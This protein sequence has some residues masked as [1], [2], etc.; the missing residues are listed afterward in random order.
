MDAT[1]YNESM[2]TDAAEAILIGHY[3]VNDK[4]KWKNSHGDGDSNSDRDRNKNLMIAS[5]IQN[6]ES[7]ILNSSLNL[8]SHHITDTPPTM[9]KSKGSKELF[10][11][12]LIE[13]FSN[14]N[15]VLPPK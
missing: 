5:N 10:S 14:G 15:V 6:E 2:N 1:Y 3:A 13:R 9:Y 8:N 7:L 12:P 4:L 11:A